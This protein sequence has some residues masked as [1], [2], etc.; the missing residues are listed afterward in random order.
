MKP[1]FTALIMIAVGFFLAP[2]L[3]QTQKSTNM[4]FVTVGLEWESVPDAKAYEI[5]ILSAHF[6]KNFQSK[7]S[8]FSVQIPLGEHKVRGR[9]QDYRGVYGEWSEFVLFSAVP[10][11]IDLKTSSEAS[12]PIIKIDKYS[13]WVK[14]EWKPIVG[15]KKYRF[16]FKDD[17]GKILAIHDSTQPTVAFKTP[18]GRYQYNVTAVYSGNIESDPSD[19]QPSLLI[20]E[21]KIDPPQLISSASEEQ[22]KHFRLKVDPQ[23]LI[24]AKVEYSPFLGDSWDP[25]IDEKIEP[26][27]AATHFSKPGRYRIS[28]RSTLKGFADSEPIIREFQ[29]K[30]QE[31]DLQSKFSAK[32]EHMEP[33]SKTSESKT[34]VS[35]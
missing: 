18:P 35:K 17:K 10:Q 6:Q 24:K 23:I 2:G 15:V 4:S 34:N 13:S 30:P 7:S 14:I 21:R 28:F 11:K 12:Q 29:I 31:S 20:S 22:H 25:L 16:Y 27:Y 19:F 3:A 5:E 9:S 26:S 8:F 33:L 1:R 32:A